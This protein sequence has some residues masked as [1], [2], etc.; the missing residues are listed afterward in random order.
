VR[1]PGK[2]LADLAGRPIVEWVHS[3]AA[4]C[5]HFA[6]V[7]VAT[8]DE[9]IADC[10]NRFG[11]EV[12]LTRADHATGSDRVAEVAARHPEMDVVVNVQGDQP[13][14]TASQLSEL[15]APYLEGASPDMTTLACPLDL[16]GASNPNVV[17]VV[18]DRNDN[19]LY[20]SRAQIPSGPGR[21]QYDYL[22]HLGL[23]GF[24]ADFLPVF[25]ELAQTP[26][27]QCEQ[28]EQLRVLEHGYRI[29]VRTTSESVVEV[30]TPEDLEEAEALLARMGAT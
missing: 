19:A 11:G 4:S 16:A 23:Y 2:P 17:K 25:A 20:F 5:P 13:F 27:E 1:F 29:V 14:V 8:D 12:E 9:R 22:Q 24:R 18:C 21:E 7:L 10:V 26:L 3:A 15:V 28:L 30:N 6:R